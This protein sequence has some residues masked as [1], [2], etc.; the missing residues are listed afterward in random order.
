MTQNVD[1]EFCETDRAD[2]DHTEGYSGV[3]R[4]EKF[5]ARHGDRNSAQEC[6]GAKSGEISGAIKVAFL[7]VENSIRHES[8]NN[9]DENHVEDFEEH[10]H[11]IDFDELASKDFHQKGSHERRDE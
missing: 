2:Q 9:G 8:G 5:C 11:E 10:F 3:K 4:P 7:A 1:E 6:R